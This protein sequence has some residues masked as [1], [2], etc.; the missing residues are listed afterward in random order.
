MASKNDKAPIDVTWDDQ[1]NICTFGRMHRR[2]QQLQMLI[3]NKN[4]NMEDISDAADEIY[5]SDT[6]RFVFGEAFVCVDTN[7]AEELLAQ[8]K[9][10]EQSEL[11]KLKKEFT[12]LEEAMK[13]LKAKLYA[14]FGSQIYL[15]NE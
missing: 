10:F 13:K 7:G 11:D 8:R 12:E 1:R 4:K 5:I 3:K 14:K 9:A 2:H 15:E 6:T